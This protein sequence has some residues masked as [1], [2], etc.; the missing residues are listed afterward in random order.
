[1]PIKCSVSDLMASLRHKLSLN[2]KF[3]IDRILFLETLDCREVFDYSLQIQKY[4]LR[5]YADNEQ[6]KLVMREDV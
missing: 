5:N 1:M 6:L 2:Q 4:E 3:P